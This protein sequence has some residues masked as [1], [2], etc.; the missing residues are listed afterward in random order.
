[1]KKGF[2]LAEVLITLGVIGIVAV[3][4]VPGVMKNYK[5]RLY[6][7]Q[8]EKTYSQIA[9]ATQAIMNS[10][11][12]DNFYETTAGQAQSCSDADSGKC[13]AGVGY[14]LNNYF[15]SIKRNCLASG[16][17][18]C[19]SS[20]SSVYKSIS[21]AALSSNILDYCVQ[22]VSGAAI[23]G[24]YNP[25]NK[26]E[27]F[28]IDVNG[29]AEPNVSGRDVF[30][31]DIHKDGSISDFGSGCRDGNSGWSAALCA[32]KNDTI[33]NSAAGCLTS[34]IEAGWKMNY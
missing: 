3:L 21:G 15:K 19:M 30:S 13:E 16:K 5:N 34:V 9:D 31:M 29:I 23:C 14:F 1:M 7:A 33:A 8:L 22:T 20:S 32:T 24:A 17:S 10:E 18:G 25:N 28:V 26:C 6:V 11:H 27:S 4:T 2:T 12:V